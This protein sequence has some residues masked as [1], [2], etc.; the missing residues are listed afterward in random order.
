MITAAALRCGFGGGLVVA[1]WQGISQASLGV[2][3]EV[4]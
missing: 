2:S 1:T 3:V 4:P